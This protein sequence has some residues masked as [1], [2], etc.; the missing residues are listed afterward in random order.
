MSEENMEQELKILPSVTR[1]VN[2][3]I[4]G[5]AIVG[6]IMDY[7]IYAVMMECHFNAVPKKLMFYRPMWKI[8][9]GRLVWKN[10]LNLVSRT[11]D[12]IV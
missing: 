1:S 4:V 10:S 5:Y 6:R 3:K 2:T 12:N 11:N 7:I 9:P 8:V